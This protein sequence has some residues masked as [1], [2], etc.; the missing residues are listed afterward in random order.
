MDHT[1]CPFGGYNEQI[2]LTVMPWAT[3]AP[4]CWN[5]P[6]PF[7]LGFVAEDHGVSQNPFK[8]EFARGLFEEGREQCR[9]AKKLRAINEGAE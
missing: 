8:S 5:S 7:R 9:E 3:L 4:L 6:T 2:D 1:K